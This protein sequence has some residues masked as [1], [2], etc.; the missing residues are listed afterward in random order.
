MAPPALKRPFDLPARWAAAALV[1]LPLLLFY[2]SLLGGQMLWGGDIQAIALPFN[3]FVRRCLD[4]GQWPLWMPDIFC[5]MPGIAGTTLVFL[6]PTDFLMHLL[7]VPVTAGFGLDAAIQV[8]LSGFG[9]FGL[10]R[11][12]GLS[13]SASLLGAL[14][15]AA[16]GTQLSLIYAGHTTNVK[17]I[18]AIPWAFWAAHEAFRRRSFALWALC[19]AA[20]ALQVL[21]IG[22]QVFAYT[23]IGLASFTAWLAWSGRGEAP[24]EGNEGTDAAPGASGPW[25]HALAGL[26]LAGVFS[27]LLSAPQLL[28]SLQYKAYSWRE[29]FTYEDFTSWSFDPREALTWVVPGFWG[30]REPSY[31]GEWP[32]C[33]TTEYFGVLPWALAAAGLAGAWA[34]AGARGVLRRPEAF[35]AGLAAFSF[36]AAVGKHFPLHLLFYHLPV[37]NGFRTWVRFLCLLTL[38]VS[39][40]AAF[41]WDALLSLSWSA[42]FKGGLAAVALGIGLGVLALVAGASSVASA[43]GLLVQKLGADGPAQALDLARSSALHSLAACG[44]LLAAL[45]SWQR[46]RGAGALLLAGAVLL[47]GWDVDQVRERY[48]EFRQPAAMLQEPSALA[49]LPDPAGAEPYRVLDLPGAWTQNTLCLFGFEALQ[50]YHGV[51]MSAPVKLQKALSARQMDWLN[52]LG[53][54]YI[55]SPQPIHLPGGRTLNAQAPWLTENPAALPRAQVLG[56]SI[57]AAGDDE[58]YAQLGLPSWRPDRDVVLTNGPALDGSGFAGGQASWVERG[59]TRERLKVSL[60]GRG[61]LLLAQTWYP[62]WSALVDGR[63]QSVLKADGAL[64][65]LV[66]EAGDHDVQMDYTE[67]LLWWGLGALAVGLAAL[68]ALGW[69]ERRRAPTA[70]SAASAPGLPARPAKK[71]A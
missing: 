11:S 61:I 39:V 40:L 18:A 21:G 67:P 7:R 65:G 54:R 49:G 51:Q 58:A 38:S 53:A 27:A 3:L 25:L 19:G 20:L 62:G 43:S 30:W 60:R 48:L 16:S 59:A 29:G 36:L 44:A 42:A 17:A 23:V 10:C 46:L 32:F 41:G 50:G 33:L 70:S 1:A 4:Q 52:L 35:F 64:Q 57:P 24:K 8:C 47:Q 9:V 12:F 28:P 13:R 37:F 15:F 45:L 26:A 5:G 68:V 34:L 56:R 2:P 6:Y 31:H 55:V 14:A 63:P 69:R 22:M 66:L 71:G